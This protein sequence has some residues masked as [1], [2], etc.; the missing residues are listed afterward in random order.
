LNGIAGEIEVEGNPYN[1][2]MPGHSFLTDEE[3]SQLSTF[4]RQSFGNHA[5]AVLPAEVADIRAHP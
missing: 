2:V 5:P 1:G 3:V 4:L